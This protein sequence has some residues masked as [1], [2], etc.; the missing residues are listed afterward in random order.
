MK[1]FLTQY[2]FGSLRGI[3]VGLFLYAAGAALLLQLVVLPYWLP[4]LHAGNGLMTGGDWVGFH[5][6]AAELA[7]KINQQGWSAWELRPGR[8]A[9]AGIAAVF[10][11]FLGPHPWALVPLNAAVHATTGILLVSILRPFASDLRNALVCVLPFIFFPSALVWYAQIHKDGIFFLG[12]FSCLYGWILLSRFNLW[13]RGY[14]HVLVSLFFLLAGTFLVWVMRPYGVKLMQGMGCIF[15]I[16]LVAHFLVGAWQKKLGIGHAVVAVLIVVAVPAGLGVFE[17]RGKSGEVT[18]VTDSMLNDVRP[19]DTPATVGEEERV[20][21][22]SHKVQNVI[23]ELQWKKTDWLPSALDNAFL[24]LAIIRS[25]YAGSKGGSNIDADVL[26]HSA[27]EFFPYLP[28]AIQ[29]GFT[30]PFPATWFRLTATN[31]SALLKRISAVEMVFVYVSL[32]FLPCALWR[33]RRSMEIWLAFGFSATLLLLYTYITPNIG[34]L[35]RSRHGFL[36]LL[37]AL[38]IAGAIAARQRL[39]S[40]KS[41][42]LAISARRQ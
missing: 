3:W 18:L 39:A 19:A 11:V 20:G 24:T 31:D 28:R 23:A 16:V 30:A 1:Q 32:L 4:G 35:Y 2:F 15:A 38:G 36:M 10:Y 27:H 9:P 29:I 8:Q 34:S 33:W 12:I 41:L 6:F 13:T 7:E 37:V 17:D 25:G 5:Q 21:S 26:F 42:R 22:F 14:V 40:E